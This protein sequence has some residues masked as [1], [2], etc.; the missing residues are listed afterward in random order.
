MLNRWLIKAAPTAKDPQRRLLY[1]KGTWTDVHALVRRLGP[2]CGRPKKESSDPDFNYSIVLHKLE[3]AALS[4]VEAS[5]RS[6][7]G[8]AAGVTKAMP[9]QKSTLPPAPEP[10]APPPT[11][12][13]AILPP[14]TP[15]PVTAP[16]AEKTLSLPPAPEKPAD[17]ANPF[18]GFGGQALPFKRAT[19]HEPLSPPFEPPPPAAPGAPTSTVFPKPA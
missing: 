12:P 19:A 7:T 16:A 18:A 4:E 13:P 9:V 10:A 17:P 5:V 1:V 2:V 6:L 3:D 11:P 8:R 15:L 14:P